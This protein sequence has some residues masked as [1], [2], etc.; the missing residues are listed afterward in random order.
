MKGKLLRILIY[1]VLLALH[2]ASPIE[3]TSNT[4]RLH[5]SADPCVDWEDR[6]TKT[7]CIECISGY[8]LD[9]QNTCLQCS[10]YMQ[11]CSKCTGPTKC[12]ACTRG[13]YVE[14]EGRL[15]TPCVEK[16][17]ACVSEYHCTDCAEGY[18]HALRS[19]VSET[20]SFVIYV[21]LG[22]MI[23]S[24]LL[25]L[26]CLGRCLFMRNKPVDFNSLNLFQITNEE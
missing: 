11:D 17:T 25:I 23:L 22:F 7:K 14:A 12:Q 6:S 2:K 21:G 10:N 13:K 15:C 16:C 26:V 1:S 8:F 18:V 20:I 9:A 4:N 24:G 19:C 5:E 3:F